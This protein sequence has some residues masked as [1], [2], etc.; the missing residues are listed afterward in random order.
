MRC[1][2]F[3]KIGPAGI[4]PLALCS[5]FSCCL[6]DA[7]LQKRHFSETLVKERLQN[8]QQGFHRI[9]IAFPC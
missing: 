6:R 9:C 3:V 5:T 1:I 8:V 2:S 4:S 7:N